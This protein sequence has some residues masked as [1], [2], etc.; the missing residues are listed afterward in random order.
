MLALALINAG[1][2]M[3]AFPVPGPTPASTQIFRI[4]DSL[5]SVSCRRYRRV[6]RHQSGTDVP[7]ASGS[8][9]HPQDVRPEGLQTDANRKWSCGW[10]NSPVIAFVLAATQPP[11]VWVHGAGATG[12]IKVGSRCAV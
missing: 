2:I 1:S 4:P 9:L 12:E 8:C 5:L 3:A 6:E 10:L 7:E 11:P